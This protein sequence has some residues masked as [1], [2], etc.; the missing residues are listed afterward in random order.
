M[1]YVREYSSKWHPKESPTLTMPASIEHWVWQVVRKWDPGMERIPACTWPVRL[2]RPARNS[3][4]FSPQLQLAKIPQCSVAYF[5]AYFGPLWCTNILAAAH[6]YFLVSNFV[7]HKRWNLSSL[8]MGSFL[9]A[10]KWK[11]CPPCAD[12]PP[13]IWVVKLARQ[14]TRN[15]IIW[16]IKFTTKK[17]GDIHIAEKYT[18]LMTILQLSKWTGSPKN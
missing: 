15:L 4:R 9:H 12:S 17:R 1:F 16:D 13:S 10:G 5:P 14:A 7:L 2:E 18:P 8:I 11:T 6:S 3:P